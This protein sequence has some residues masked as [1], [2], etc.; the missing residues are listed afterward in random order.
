MRASEN[1]P[2]IGT[3]TVTYRDWFN[4]DKKFTIGIFGDF[5]V[6]QKFRSLGPALKLL[7]HSVDFAQQNNYLVYGF[8]N[9][10]A[11][12]V[13]RRAG[14]KPANKLTRYAKVFKS[15]E[16]LEKHAKLGKYAWLS[17][18]VDFALRLEDLLRLF[19][20][21]PYDVEFGKAA[22]PD[23][24]KLVRKAAE[25]NP[26]LF[27]GDRSQGY[28][29]WRFA[30]NP[31]CEFEFLS[32]S[33]GGELLGYAVCSSDQE[34]NFAIED[35]LVEDFNRHTQVVLSF[36]VGAIR[37]RKAK[38][39]SFT[40]SSSRTFEN[41]LQKLRFILVKHARSFWYTVTPTK[42]VISSST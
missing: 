2:I 16:A 26:E 21:L 24:A 3:E 12:P 33:K 23:T 17:P 9:R 35:F 14:F 6:D 37:K 25:S 40:C 15:R 22:H 41:S 38:S 5:F 34:G 39:L 36:V 18:L 42:R 1:L 7:R 13:F 10:K 4:G 27:I 29:N 20:R 28:L 30:H 8:P 19:S 32:V 11:Q 31:L